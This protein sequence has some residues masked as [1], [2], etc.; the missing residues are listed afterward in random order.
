MLIFVEVIC[1]L[2]TA[3]G[4]LLPQS[5]GAKGLVLA[6]TDEQARIRSRR[7]HWRRTLR[8]FAALFNGKLLMALAVLIGM[9]GIGV[10]ALAV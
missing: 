3:D 1:A 8:T 6:A 10:V 4:E 2:S 9:F 5:P 7:I